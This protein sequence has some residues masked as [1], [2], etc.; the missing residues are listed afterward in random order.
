[1][2]TTILIQRPQKYKSLGLDTESQYLCLPVRTT[3]L[4]R[5]YVNRCTCALILGASAVPLQSLPARDEERPGIDERPTRCRA[6]KS[7]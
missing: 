2:L 1:M 6:D 5:P 7:L 4:F 3:L